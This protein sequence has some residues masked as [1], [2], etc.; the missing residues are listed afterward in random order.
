[1]R[2]I[3]SI[4]LLII[5][6]YPSYGQDWEQ[7]FYNERVNVLELEKEFMEYWNDKNLAKEGGEYKQY[8]RM[9][10]SM[11]KRINSKGILQKPIPIGELAA[12]HKK[13]DLIKRQQ[14]NIIEPWVFLGPSKSPASDHRLVYNQGVGRITSIA[15]HPNRSNRLMAGAHT[16]GI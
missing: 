2:T 9:L 4:I 11:K 14:N 10:H 8:A 5:F 12:L 13:N 3:N 1:M 16:G 7:K 6:I 15:W